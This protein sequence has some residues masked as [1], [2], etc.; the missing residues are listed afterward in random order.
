MISAPLAGLIREGTVW[1]VASCAGRSPSMGAMLMPAPVTTLDQRYSDPAATAT[2]W[3][4]TRRV[5]EEAELFWLSTVRAGGRPHVTP[6]VA[7]WAEGAIW[8]STGAG[9]Q[10]FANLRGN[11]HVVLTTGCNRWDGG[12]DVVVEGKAVQVTDDAV[13]GRVAGAFAARWDGRWQF[14]ARGGCFRDPGG[15]GEAMVFSVTPAKVFAYAK[16]DP[17][18]ATTYRFPPA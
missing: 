18:G 5:L 9:E 6:V 3:E 2:G 7:A 16:G 8:F 17:F 1:A 11:S 15:S 12:L 4:E 13:L 14:T 10:K